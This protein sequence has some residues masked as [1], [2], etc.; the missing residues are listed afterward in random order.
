MGRLAAWRD[1]RA[2]GYR[3][4]RGDTHGYRTRTQG[5]EGGRLRAR[6]ARMESRGQ[7]RR[8]RARRTRV[9][10][11]ALSAHRGKG[12]TRQR[13]RCAGRFQ[14]GRREVGTGST[15]FWG[16]SFSPC[17]LETEPMH[18][19]DFTR[20]VRLL[21]SC[22]SYFDAVAARVSPTMAKGPRG[23]GR[24]RDHIIGHTIRV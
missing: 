16:I 4:A 21:R 23:G 20:K 10:P 19:A 2:L 5:Q 18:D 15:D 9:V 1:V 14:G 17:R 12:A 3:P 8:R 22:W 24:E 6:L 13:V 7:D 11:R